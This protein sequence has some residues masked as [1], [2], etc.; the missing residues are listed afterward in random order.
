[1][2]EVESTADAAPQRHWLVRIPT[3][4]LASFIISSI[5]LSIWTGLIGDHVPDA[6]ND[7][8][9]PLLLFVLAPVLT[10]AFLRG[11]R[12]PVRIAVGLASLWIWVF[13]IFLVLIPITG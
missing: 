8:V 2:T 12:W 3:A 10:A 9:G 13:W 4:I 1:M 6:V 7:F 5:V 11:S